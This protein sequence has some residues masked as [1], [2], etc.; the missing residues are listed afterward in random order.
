MKSSN[1]K[2]LGSEEPGEWSWGV[3]KQGITSPPCL[4]MGG[5]VNGVRI[6]FSLTKLRN[7]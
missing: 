6:L 1:V 3:G 7:L 5:M 4:P 2:L